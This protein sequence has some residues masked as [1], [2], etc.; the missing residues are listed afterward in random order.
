[1][2]LERR[3]NIDPPRKTKNG[4]RAAIGDVLPGEI[5]VSKSMTFTDSCSVLCCCY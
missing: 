2:L 4:Q 5:V 3:Q 1:M